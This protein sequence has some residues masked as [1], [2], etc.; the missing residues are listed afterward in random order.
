MAPTTAQ[1][2]EAVI[3]HHLQAVTG[4]TG[5][6][7]I[8]KDYADDSL[9]LTQNGPMRGLKEIRLFFEGFVAGLTP[10][11]LSNLHV[12]RLDFEGE[13][14]YLVFAAKPLT[15]LGTDTFFVRDGKIMA[16]TFTVLG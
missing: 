12:I 6:D 10:E 11:V 5:I 2:T 13:I 7:E 9:L 8:L 16:Q 14:A 15:S 1:Q 4:G 3:T